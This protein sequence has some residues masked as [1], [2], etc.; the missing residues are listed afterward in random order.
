MVKNIHTGSKFEDFLEENAILEEC[1]A[2]ALKFMLAEEMQKKI[3][4]QHLSKSEVARLIKTSRAGLMRLLD[5]EVKSITLQT[6]SKMANFVG[7]RIEVKL[8][9]AH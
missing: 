3:K 1:T 2:S 6:L 9:D 7:K 4:K 8:A 5:P